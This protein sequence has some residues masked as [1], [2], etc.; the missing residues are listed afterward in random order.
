M[1]DAALLVID[2]QEAL[3]DDAHDVEACLGTVARLAEQ[4]RSAGVPVVYLR[5][6]LDDVPADLADVHPAVAPRPGDAV[7]PPGVPSPGHRRP[8]SA[9]P[10]R[11]R[12]R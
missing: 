1:P 12:A 4:A 9:S 10:P 7:R 11:P 6:R 8:G 3:L 2:M 5:Q